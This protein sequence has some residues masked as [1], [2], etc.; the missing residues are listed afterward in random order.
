MNLPHY[1]NKLEQAGVAFTSGLTQTEIQQ[2]ENSLNFSFPPDLKSFLMYALPISHGF[3]NW[4]DEDK[5]KLLTRLAWPYEGICFDIEHNS[6]WLE[7]WGKK[8][9]IHT[10]A[11]KVARKAIM[12]APTL[13]PISGHRYM[14]DRPNEIDNPVFSVYQTDI[15]HYGCNLAEY[16]ENEFYYYFD[17]SGYIINGTPKH[18][19]FWS[20]L[21]GL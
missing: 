3:V 18:I 11:F 9:T 15:I 14:P 6:F 19:E 2:I 1:K 12:R 5:D 20:Y 21:T 16:L 4:R 13:I 7:E 10:K 8:P 17:R